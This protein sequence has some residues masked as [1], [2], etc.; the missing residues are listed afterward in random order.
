MQHM[1]KRRHFPRI[2]RWEGISYGFAKGAG[3]GIIPPALV[4]FGILCKRRSWWFCPEQKFSFF[5]SPRIIGLF[6]RSRP[7]RRTFG[8]KETVLH[9]GR[10]TDAVFPAQSE[11][12]QRRL[13]VDGVFPFA[14]HGAHRQG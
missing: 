3:S 4:V 10:C 14:G 7:Y 11:A 1:E 2:T 13:P 6:G 12:I 8:A 9:S 5:P